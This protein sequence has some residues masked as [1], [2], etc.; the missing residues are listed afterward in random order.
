MNSRHGYEYASGGEVLV[1]TPLTERSYLS[2]A[3][4]AHLSMGGAA[5]GPAASGKTETV[6]ALAREV[7]VWAVLFCSRR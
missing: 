1:V 4:A 5:S 2:L 6:R 7:G 3:R